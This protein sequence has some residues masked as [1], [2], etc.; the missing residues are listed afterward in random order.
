MFGFISLLLNGDDCPFF[1]N[2]KR[3]IELRNPLNL[4]DLKHINLRKINIH[5][6]ETGVE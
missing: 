3:K 5:L 4:R 6:L 2:L 1:F